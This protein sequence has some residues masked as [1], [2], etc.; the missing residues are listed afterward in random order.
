MRMNVVLQGDCLDIMRKLPDACVDMV[1][2][3][4]PYGTTQCKWDS[5]IPFEPLWTQY[6]RVA[7]P[8]AAFVFTAAQPFTSALVMSQPKLFKYDWTWRK[9]GRP[10]GHLNVKKMPLRDKEDV[11]I[12]GRG[13]ICYNPQKTEGKPY[14]GNGRSKHAQGNQTYGLHGTHRNDN[15]GFRYPRQVFECRSVNSQHTIHPTEKP[16]EL[17]RYLIRTYSNKGETILDNCIGSGTT[18]VATPAEGRK[19]IGI[20]KDKDYAALARRRVEAFLAGDEGFTKRERM[21]RSLL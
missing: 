9:L 5:I 4:L 12:F 6:L 7:K 13:T 14:K 16:V 1:L 19:F 15:D 8:S 11:L 20:E 17:F 3:D 21:I 2:C 10:T 18:A